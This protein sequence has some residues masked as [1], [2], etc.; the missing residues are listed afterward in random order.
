MHNGATPTPRRLMVHSVECDQRVQRVTAVIKRELKLLQDAH[1][2]LNG[3]LPNERK[4][5]IADDHIQR[6][7]ISLRAAIG[8]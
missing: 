1:D 5:A 3:K 7:M 4:L 2:A 6:A 8:K